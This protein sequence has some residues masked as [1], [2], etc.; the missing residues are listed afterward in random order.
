MTEWGVESG[1]DP[2]F[3]SRLFAWVEAHPRCKMLVYYQDFGSTSSYRIQN[4]S[5]SLSRAGDARLH[6]GLFPT[7][8][9]GAPRL[10]PP[11]PG[12]VAAR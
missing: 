5:Q 9:P 7:Y 6:S 8:A 1:D 10:P 4:Y 3:V 2:T 12:G 11:P